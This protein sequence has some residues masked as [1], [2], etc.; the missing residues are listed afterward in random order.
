[1]MGL[2]V[3]L[4]L[5]IFHFFFVIVRLAWPV[6]LILLAVWFLRRWKRGASCH[7]GYRAEKEKTSDFKGPVYTVDYEEVD[8]ED[9][10]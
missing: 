3:G 6:L 1:M 7:T 5:K 4:P 10:P 2:L 8:E 9:G